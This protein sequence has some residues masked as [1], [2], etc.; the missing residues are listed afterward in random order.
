GQLPVDLENVLA[1]ESLVHEVR[2]RAPETA[3][4]VEPFPPPDELCVR[5]PEGAFVHEL[6]VPFVR[7]ATPPRRAARRPSSVLPVPRLLP[8]GSAWLYARLYTGETV[9]DG[10][11]T[12]TIGPFA[13]GLLDDGAIDR[14]FFMRYR[15]PE[16]HLRVRFRGN[17]ERLHADV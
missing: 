8:P 9:A 4:L 10:L 17:P 2:G 1:V 13:R 7:T 6:I 15:D 5:G 12:D 11:L 16:F 14:W 3:V